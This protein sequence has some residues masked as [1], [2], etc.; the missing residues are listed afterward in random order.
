M[1][2]QES[3]CSTQQ[4]LTSNWLMPP[5]QVHSQPMYRSR[6]STQTPTTTPPA[7]LMSNNNASKFSF[8]RLRLRYVLVMSVLRLCW[9]YFYLSAAQMN[10]A[11][12]LPAGYHVLPNGGTP[13]PGLDQTGSAHPGTMPQRIQL[14]S[15]NV[16]NV[17]YYDDNQQ[18]S[19]L[20]L[21]VTCC[22]A[23]C[24]G[25]LYLLLITCGPVQ[26]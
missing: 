24:H 1:L 19:A 22:G 8:L 10:V 25:P 23:S 5:P 4:P 9:N 17:N 7:Y 12:G 11:G 2:R 20:D 15:N 3:L 13:G 6:V 26:T 14:L 21:F 18:V 16:D